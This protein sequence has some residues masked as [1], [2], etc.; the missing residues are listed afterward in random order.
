MSDDLIYFEDS[1]YNESSPYSKKIESRVKKTNKRQ[2]EGSLNEGGGKK[3]KK[4]KQKRG[5]IKN[6]IRKILG[7]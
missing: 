7:F 4:D 1:F 3:M 5:K 2:C 6:E